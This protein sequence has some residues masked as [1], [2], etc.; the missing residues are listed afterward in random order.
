MGYF[1]DLLEKPLYAPFEQ[2]A[3]IDTKYIAQAPYTLILKRSSG[4]FSK[5]EYKLKDSSNKRYF[6][7]T[8][9]TNRK[10]VFNA[11]EQ[12]LFNFST[13]PQSVVMLYD[14]KKS[15]KTVVSIEERETPQGLH[16]KR[17]YVSYTNLLNNQ[18]RAFDMNC[19]KKFCCCGI[20]YGQE[21]MGAPMVCKISQIPRSDRFKVEIQPGIDMALMFGL[22]LV[23]L[24]KGKNYRLNKQ[25]GAQNKVHSSGKHHSGK[26]HHSSGKHSSGKSKL[27]YAGAGIAGLAGGY[28]LGKLGHHGLHHGHGYYYHGYPEYGYGRPSSD[29]GSHSD[30]SSVSSA[31]SYS[32]SDYS[33]YSGDEND[34]ADYEGFN[35]YDNYNDGGFGGY[36]GGYDGGYNNNYGYDVGYDGGYDGGFDGGDFG[37]F[38]GGD[39]GGGDW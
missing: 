31:S 7:N 13:T 24:E 12:P 18:P 39:F 29:N 5:F 2:L 38:D 8:I 15:D 30:A 35:E 10:V 6:S 27:P 20:F 34:Y 22:A 4:L 33:G 14:G 3:A 25:R 17:F 32:N 11:E 21:E 16:G 28:A 26:H 9:K 1:K 19:D 36:D 23:F 37:G